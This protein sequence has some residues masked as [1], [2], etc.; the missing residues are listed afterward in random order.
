MPPII[1][2]A[3]LSL[4]K[5]TRNNGTRKACKITAT[6][7]Y[8]IREHLIIQKIKVTPKSIDFILGIEAKFSL[9]SKTDQTH[10][11]SNKNG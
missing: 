5:N 8:L 10:K 4:L 6:S 2:P 9:L 1:D 11:C 7:K 3:I